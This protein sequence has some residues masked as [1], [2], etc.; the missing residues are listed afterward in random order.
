MVTSL[1]SVN[2]QAT[3]QIMKLFYKYMKKGWTKDCAL[4]QAKLDFIEKGSQKTAHPFLWSAF[5]QIGDAEPVPSLVPFDYMYW[6]C[7]IGGSFL[8]L[9]IGIVLFRKMKN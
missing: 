8:S 6:I 4:R 1:W 9:F 2:D 5:I 3:S 7:I